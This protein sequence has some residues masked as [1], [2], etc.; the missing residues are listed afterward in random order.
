MKLIPASIA[1]CTMRTQS[2]WSGL[3]TAPN[4]MAPRQSG[5]TLMP[6]AP[7]VRKSMLLIEAGYRRYPASPSSEIVCDRA[8]ECP[9]REV[10]RFARTSGSVDIGYAGDVIHVRQILD[11][12]RIGEPVAGSIRQLRVEDRTSRRAIHQL[13]EFGQVVAGLVVDVSAPRQ[14]AVARQPQRFEI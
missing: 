9:G 3:P 10:R 11:I 13:F 8:P 6:V 12:G 7:R 4:I 1:R 2:S 5:L 14:Q